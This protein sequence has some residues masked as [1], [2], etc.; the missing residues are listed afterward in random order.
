L[1]W[2]SL[3]GVTTSKK[4]ITK[5]RLVL[6]RRMIAWRVAFFVST[7]VLPTISALA[8]FNYEYGPDEYVTIANGISPDEKYAITAHGGGELGYDN[9]HLYLTDAITGKNIG[10]LEEIVETLDTGAGAFSAKWSSDSKQVIIIY[11]VDRHAPLKAV[12]YRVAGRRA[13]CIKGPF[14]V[15]SDELIKYWQ[16]HSSTTQPSAKIFG[17]PL[18]QK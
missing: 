7:L 10:P 9:F 14:D 4:Q 6:V 8:T 11:R 17:T 5:C 18:K 12:S 1:L 16:I 3:F 15:K 2:L 13:R